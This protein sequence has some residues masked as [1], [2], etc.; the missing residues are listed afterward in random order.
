MEQLLRDGWARGDSKATIAANIGMD[1]TANAVGGRARRLNLGPHPN[2]K[3]G[4]DTVSR[5]AN[6]PRKTAS[7]ADSKSTESKSPPGK[8]GM[9]ATPISRFTY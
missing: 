9:P 2:S 1:I 8:P 5:V 4:P 3:V 7:I 6:V